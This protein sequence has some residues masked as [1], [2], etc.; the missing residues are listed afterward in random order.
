[1]RSVREWRRGGLERSST[2]DRTAELA[3]RV[4]C[5]V[6]EVGQRVSLGPKEENVSKKRAWSAVSAVE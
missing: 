5:G 3:M 6:R 2:E 1:M 4:A